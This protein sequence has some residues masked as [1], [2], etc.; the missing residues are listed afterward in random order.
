MAVQFHIKTFSTPSD[1]FYIYKL[2][3]NG[4]DCIFLDSSKRELPYG[5]DSIIG[6]NPF[7]TVKYE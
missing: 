4:K 2:V 7:F 6:V 1:A 3:E 5:G